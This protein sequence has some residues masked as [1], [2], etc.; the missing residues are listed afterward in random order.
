MN[1][2]NLDKPASESEITFEIGK[3][4]TRQQI[5]Q[6]LGG[7]Q[8]SYLPQRHK[9]IVC[10]CFN[11]ERNPQAPEIILIENKTKVIEKAQLLLSQNEAIPVFV[12]RLS[13]NWVYQGYYHLQNYSQNQEEIA[14]MQALSF[15]DNIIAV[16]HLQ[17]AN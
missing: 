11:L 17:K 8:S 10:G 2:I 13:S 9:K 7:D 1:I 4:Y 3:P 6:V 12:K 15:R 5:H 16:L 14:Q